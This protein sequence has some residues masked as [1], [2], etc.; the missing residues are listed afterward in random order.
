MS[1]SLYGTDQEICIIILHKLKQLLLTYCRGVRPL[2]WLFFEVACW[3]QWLCRFITGQFVKMAHSTCIPDYC[4]NLSPFPSKTFVNGK[5][6]VL[7][8][9]SGLKETFCTKYYKEGWSYTWNQ[10]NLSLWLYRPMNLGNF[11]SF[12]IL[13]T[14]GSTPWT[15]DQPIT[16]L[17]PPYR[18]T[19]T[20][21]KC[22]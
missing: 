1:K 11:F 6:E 18:T 20:Q 19:Q 7:W 4:G 3:R 17:L 5:Q 13:H 14:A 8:L 15:G 16:R 10:G 12:L 21:N 22:T 2:I 9:V